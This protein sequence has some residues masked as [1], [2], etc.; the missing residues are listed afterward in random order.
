[1][2]QSV[3]VGLCN[4]GVQPALAAGCPRSGLVVVVASAVRLVREG[5]SA[6]LRGRDGIAALHAIGLDDGWPALV[7]RL[8]PEIV[9]VD[10][11][12]AAIAA[13]GQVLRAACPT[14]RLVAFALDEVDDHVF[15][16]AAAGFAGY[17]ARDGD[18]DDLYRTVLDTAQGRMTCAPH[19]TAALFGRLADLLRPRGPAGGPQLTARESEIVG[20]ADEGC[21]NKEIAR[22]LTISTATVKN[23]MHNILQK[24]QVARRGQAAARLRLPR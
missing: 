23:H 1:M 7:A 11:H 17:V 3:P 12:G 21:S 8:A 20:L 15:A 9:L 14:A 16:C 2:R 5:L 19:I 10:L 6:S 22:R 18:A 24:L 13:T 4:E